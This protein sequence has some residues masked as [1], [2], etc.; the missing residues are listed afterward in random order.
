M[1]K[2]ITDKLIWLFL[3][4]PGFLSVSLVGLIVDLGQL[5]E[6]QITFYSFVLT[7]IDIAVALPVCWVAF[8]LIR[9]FRPSLLDGDTPKYVFCFA[10]VLVSIPM[11]IFLGL[12]A[13]KDS[14][15]VA[16]RALPITDALNK[17]SSSRPVVFLLSQNSVGK[18]DVEG[19][20]R[21]KGFKQTEAWA[22]IQMKNG[23]SFE[24]WPEFY[25]TGSKPSEIYLSPACEVITEPGKP[26]DLLRPIKGPGIILYESEIQ[27]IE[28]MDR[29]ASVCFAHWLPASKTPQSGRQQSDPGK[30]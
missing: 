17:R 24:G 5:S 26:G 14:F 4:L 7:L 29:A 16:L 19:D 11:G 13:E 30:P 28:L 2:E 6:F 21:P 23:K 25:E 10:I 15:F 3:L 20:G 8:T 27:S 22:L 18:L 9:K 12:A 1:P